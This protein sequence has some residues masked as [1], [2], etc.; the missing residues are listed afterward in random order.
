MRKQYHLRPS[1]RGVMAWHVD[2]LVRLSEDF[3]VKKVELDNILDLDTVYWF[4]DKDTPPTCR[5]ILEHIRLVEATNFDHPNNTVCKWGSYGRDAPGALLG[6][7]VIDAVQFEDDPKPDYVGVHPD[8][9]P[10]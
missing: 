4:Q 2:R 8:D 3:P 1:E 5:T 7:S 9:L 6:N 10:Y